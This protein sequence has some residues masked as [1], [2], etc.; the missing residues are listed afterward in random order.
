M[1]FVPVCGRSALVACDNPVMNSREHTTDIPSGRGDLSDGRSDTPTVVLGVTGCIAAYKAC[2]IVRTLVGDGVTVQAVMTEAATRFIGPLTLRT[3]TGRPVITSLWDDAA[4]SAPV[5]H[6]SLAHEIDVMLV[7]PCTANVLAKLASGRADDMLTTTVLATEA[8][9]VIAPAMNTHMWRAEATVANIETLRARGAIIVEP[10]TGQLACGD[11]GEGRLA[12]IEEIVEAVRAELCRV[13]DLVGV[14]VLVTAG[15]T[16]EPIDPVRFLGN[17]SSGLTGYL[18]AEEAARRGADVTLVSGPTTLPDPFDVA[19]VRVRTAEEMLDAA[20]EA[21]AT[22]DVL[23]ATAAVADYRPAHP[24]VEKIKKGEERLSLELVRTPDI[25]GTL[26]EDKGARL[27]VGFAAET[28][29]VLHRAREKLERKSLDMV[30]A[31]DVSNPELGFGT[32]DNR[33]A[34]VDA[35]GVRDLPVCSKRAIARELV[36]EIARRFARRA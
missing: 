7:A 24:A 15:P 32:R 9:L 31:N 34:F 5:Y 16:Y 22:A 28:S 33:V 30:V 29:D 25:L 17:R 8:P 18:I 19:I 6:L 36:D 11:T 35:D 23:I 26:A 1:E 27:L 21:Y 2:E 4:G 20:Q 12:P 14:R 13:R 3:L 10:G